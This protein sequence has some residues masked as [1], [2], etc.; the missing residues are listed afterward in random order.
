MQ[1]QFTITAKTLIEGP[2]FLVWGGGKG[3]IHVNK[4]LF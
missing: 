1:D 2:N 3:L 4:Q